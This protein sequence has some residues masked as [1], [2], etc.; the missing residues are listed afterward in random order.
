VGEKSGTSDLEWVAGLVGA[1]SDGN[2]PVPVGLALAAFPSATRPRLLVPLEPRRAAARS[3]LM[4]GSSGS[5]LG[6]VARVA[7]WAGLRSGLV[8]PLL[9]H[10]VRLPASVL[11]QS[12][13]R[14]LEDVFNARVA[15]AIRIPPSRPNRKPLIQVLA[16]R[17]K[18]LGY[19]KVGWSDLTRS[20]VRNEAAVLEGLGRRSPALSFDVPRVLH[21]GSWGDLELLVLHPLPER[22]DRGRALPGDVV[23]RATSCVAA[24]ATQSDVPLA[25]SDHWRTARARAIDLD[26]RLAGL[27]EQIGGRYGDCVLRLGGSHGDWA[28]W[29]MGCV[30]HGGRLAVW[31]WERSAHGVPVGLDAVHFEFHTAQATRGV[32]AD[33]A[34]R[35]VLRGTGLLHALDIPKQHHLPLT[36]LHLLEMTLRW[37]EG[38]RGGVDV[39][40]A[41]YRPALQRLL[42][43]GPL[44]ERMEPSG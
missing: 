20:L 15:L 14:Y 5:A 4:S 44:N 34:V 27:A 11:S 31:D 36:V 6:R 13:L 23:R 8:Q 12:L 28:P 22:L 16:P 35:S 26:P 24:L 32:A 40:D 9:R 21:R 39:S 2:A 7:A 25:E 42:A 30:R 1:L 17:G 33:R 37:E 3:V 10:R 19:V 38:R 43:G 29:N 41:V 18:V